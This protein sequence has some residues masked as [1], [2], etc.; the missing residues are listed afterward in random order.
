MKNN[1]IE[2]KTG[3]YK[4]VS[5][6]DNLAFLATN[7]K[8]EIALSLYSIKLKKVALGKSLSPQQITNIFAEMNPEN[9]NDSELIIV[10]IVGGQDSKQSEEYIESLVRQLQIIDGG[11]NIIN[12]KSFDV[13][14]RVHPSA[15]EIDCYHGGLRADSNIERTDFLNDLK[16]SLEEVNN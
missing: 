15:I 6:Q 1:R 9:L 3:Q 8:E 7:L 10:R 11:Q 12:I 4:I 14:S 16:R 5:I 13:G 2:I